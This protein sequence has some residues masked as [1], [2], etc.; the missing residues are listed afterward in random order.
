MEQVTKE[1]KTSKLTPAAKE[2]KQF[3]SFGE[4]TSSPAPFFQTKLTINQPN[5]AFEQE[6]DAIADGVMRIKDPAPQQTFFTPSGIQRECDHCEEEEK[7]QMK[8]APGIQRQEATEEEPPVEEGPPA[9]PSMPPLQLRPPDATDYFGLSQTF[10]NRGVLFPG[11]YMDSAQLEWGRQYS[12]YSQFGVGNLIGRTFLGSTLG[13]LGVT[14]PGGDWNAWL[15][16]T[17]TPMAVDS[18]LSRDFPNMNEEEERRGGLPAP[19]IIKAPAI[20]FKKDGSETGTDASAIQQTE[21]YHQSLS[22]GKPL[23]NNEKTFFESRI[24]HDFSDVQLYTD[25]TANQSAK[26]VNALAYTHGSDIVFGAGQYQPGTDA[27]KRLLAHEL[28]HVVQQRSNTNLVQRDEAAD[29]AARLAEEKKIAALTVKIKAHG[30]VSVDNGDATFTSAE[31]ELAEKA[32][33]GLP[34][35]DKASI[36]G[37]KLVRVSSLG[38]A[39]GMY[40]NEQGYDDTTVTDEQKIKLSDKAFAT[41]VTSAESIR[42]V[43]HEV[44]H[45]VASMPHRKAETAAISAGANTNKKINE[46]NTASDEFNIAND[47]LNTALDELQAAEDTLNNTDTANKGAMDA[48]R[49]DVAA[50]KKPIATLRSQRS[51][52]EAKFKTAESATAAAQL[53]QQTKETASSAKL[54]NI[55]DLKTDATTKQ[56]SMKAAYDAAKAIITGADVDSTDYRSALTSAE[57]AIIKFYDENAATDVTE[58]EADSARSV[59]EGAIAERNSKRADLAQ[60]DPNNT[61][62]TTLMPVETAQDSFFKAATVLASN[63]AMNLSVKRFYDLVTSKG[64]SPNLTKYAADNW[65]HKPEE[66]YAEAYSFFVTR[67]K[68]LEAH[69]KDLYDWFV[70]GKYK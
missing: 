37:A 2:K 67:P 26:N 7:V 48:A 46:Q 24:G 59:G 29:E 22:G 13:T 17:T 50:K 51:T 52:K 10:Q 64:I 69:S 43:T 16:N 21:N 70:A 28:T 66:F 58:S 12:L 1:V 57:D 38:S 25:S 68:D 60:K 5:D 56:A 14:P 47:A 8:Q 40:S 65:P 31:L 53:V 55:D 49:K 39:A 35:A 11:S 20:H 3:F 27:G 4:D 18:A 62:L 61:A 34:A 32:L 41:G 45:A 63:K 36:K 30:I 6:A 19:T 44:G 42:L 9:P 23:S 15:A 33:A 54:A